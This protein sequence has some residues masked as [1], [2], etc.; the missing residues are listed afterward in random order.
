[1]PTC[2]GV[3]VGAVKLLF[4]VAHIGLYL[5]EMYFKP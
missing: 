5:M 2:I 3:D 4:F 1:M